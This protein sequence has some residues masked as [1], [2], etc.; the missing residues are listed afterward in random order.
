MAEQQISEAEYLRRFRPD[1]YQRRLGLGLYRDAAPQPAAIPGL[2]GP[3]TSANAVAE[4]LAYAESFQN[5]GGRAPDDRL[6]RIERRDGPISRVVYQSREDRQAID[7]ALAGRQI[8]DQLA[9]NRVAELIAAPGPAAAGP[10]AAGLAPLADDYGAAAVLSELVGQQLDPQLAERAAQYAQILDLPPETALKLA[11]QEQQLPTGRDRGRMRAQL[12]ALPAELRQQALQSGELGRDPAVMAL[13]MAASDGILVQ[14]QTVDAQQRALEPYLAAAQQVAMQRSE[15]FATLGAAERE[16]LNAQ[17]GAGR[18]LLSTGKRNALDKVPGTTPPDPYL[19]P[20]LLA[21]ASETYTSRDG[22]LVRQPRTFRPDPLSR[23]KLFDARQVSLALLDPRAE[24]DPTLGYLRRVDPV[25]EVSGIYGGGAG[26]PT[27]EAILGDSNGL[28]SRF[29]PAAAGES[30]PMTLGQAVQDIIYRNRTPLA[31]VPNSDV[32]RRADGQLLHRQ[33]GQPLYPA[34]QGSGGYDSATYRIGRDSEY[35]TSAFQEF[36]D[37]IEAV[38]GQRLVV[39][40]RLQDPGLARLQRAALGRALDDDLLGVRGPTTF[41]AAKG[42]AAS[43]PVEG[44]N[45]TF[46][47]MRALAGGKG[48]L[49]ANTPVPPVAQN[50]SELAFYRDLLGPQM[51]Q[52]REGARQASATGQLADARPRTASINT[53]QVSELN[54]PAPPA[55]TP[56]LAAQLPEPVRPMVEQ[57]MAAAEA[58]PRRRAA[59]DFLARWMRSRA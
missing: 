11:I 45:P 37:L 15:P 38:T 18:K 3:D 9:K 28:G 14:D 27:T 8:A 51:E 32:V 29:D 58:S 43:L 4:A 52:L 42:A 30:V 1:E 41:G 36:G 34:R 12:D 48:M 21:P 23:E 31:E 2:P 10:M 17:S 54:A 6:T 44:A 56:E 7:Q 49:P 55:Y 20:A 39:N 40:E 59:V 13:Q 16:A 53:T 25:K 19:V 22:Q 5:P 47:L 26:T 33:S 24:L 35:S 46:S 57:G 50:A